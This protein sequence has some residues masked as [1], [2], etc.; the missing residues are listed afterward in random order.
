MTDSMPRPRLPYLRHEKNR[1]GTWCWY[2]R[3][4]DGLRIRMPEPYGS[5]EFKAA[6]E[7]ALSGSP[8]KRKGSE[9]G[10]LSWLVDR[11][12]E[13]A[14]FASLKPSTRRLR[15]NI[16]KSLKAKSSSQPYA[17]IERKHMQAAMD[18]K[19]STP[20][21][22]NNTLIVVSQMFA[23]AVKAEYIK[24]NPC[25]GVE[26]IKADSEGF[27]TWTAEE[28]ERYREH[29]KVGTK[30]RL[31][32][33]LL[34]FT[35]L[36]RSDL[37]RAGKQHVKTGLLTL[38]TQKTGATVYLTIWPELQHSLDATPTG[39]M[40]FL[41]SATGLPFASAQSFGNWFKA[42]C[43]EAEL[44]EHCTAHGVRKAGATIAANNGATARQLM[45]M[46]GWTRIGMAERYTKEADKIL[47]ARA[48]A[49]RI[50]NNFPPHHEQG[51]ANNPENEMKSTAEK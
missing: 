32:L 3:K 11:Y 30:A 40:A 50:A 41:T 48:A 13:S 29:H 15:D 12:K 5:D 16:L 33:D 24:A 43:R 25:D 22:A 34:L 21:Q 19:A 26:M 8:K 39:D 36:R 7:A 2:F 10:T 6:Y 51:A 28:V 35:G 44:P 1:H 9:S 47:L 31:A 20:H 38:R 46:Y 45:A 37:F 17:K 42:R 23:W 27:H 49:E 18:A 4:G 14:K